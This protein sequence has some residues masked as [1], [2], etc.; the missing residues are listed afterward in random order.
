[1]FLFILDSLGGTELLVILVVALIVFGPKKL[2]Q[3]SRSLGRSLA[4]FKRA[5]HEFQQTWERE[6]AMAELTDDAK[7][8]R[9]MLPEEN[10]SIAP[11][12]SRSNSFNSTATQPSEPESHSDVT[13]ASPVQPPSVRHVDVDPSML[14]QPETAAVETP[15][16]EP[17]RK[18]DWL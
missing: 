17:P 11:T 13:S 9:A 10:N 16:S 5:S 14:Q 12:I 18:R 3:L 6:A 15:A 8:Q 7:V 2:P 1:M 4:E